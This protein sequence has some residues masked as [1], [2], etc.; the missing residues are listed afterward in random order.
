QW[1]LGTDETGPVA[2]TASGTTPS[3]K[4]NS[5]NCHPH[6]A[7]T[8]NYAD[9]TRLITTSDGENGNR[10]IGDKGWIFVSRSRIEASD[11]KLLSEPLPENATRL[12]V[13]NNH[14]GNFMDGIR[15]RKRPICDVAIGYRSVSVC[16]LGSIALRLGKPLEWDP[17]AEHFHGAYSDEANKM[18]AREMRSPWKLEV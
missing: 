8:Y 3:D 4:P 1:G 6:F 7:V 17:S 10:F 9:G 12:Y 2:V 5:Y 13:S 15:T 11:P 16:H 18:V 14:M